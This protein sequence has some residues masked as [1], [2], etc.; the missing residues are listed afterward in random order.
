MA[1]AAKYGNPTEF[2]IELH[3]IYAAYLGYFESTDL[4]WW[5]KSWGGYFTGFNE[6]LQH[7]WEV[8]VVVNTATGRAHIAAR[9]EQ[10]ALFARMI[11]TR[12]G[13]SLPKDP[14][15]T[16]PLDPVPTKTLSLRR[17]V[18]V[19]D[20]ASYKKLSLT[21][22]AAELAFLRQ[23][24]RSGTVD[25][26]ERLFHEGDEH[27]AGYTWACVQTTWWDRGGAPSG[28]IPGSGR[29][30]SASKGLVLEVGMA[31]L[32]CANLRA[33]NVWPPVPEENYRKAH[34]IVEEWVDKR[35]NYNPPSYPRSYGFG[36]SHF[37]SEREMPRILDASIAAIASQGTENQANTLILIGCGD[38]SP[39]PLA[40]NSSV[41]NN[42][43]YLDVLALEYRFLRRARD[44]GVT[45]IPDRHGPLPHLTALLE[46]LQI[47]TTPNVP[48]GNAGNEA[49]YILLAF[50]KLMLADTSIPNVLYQVNTYQEV[51]HIRPFAHT[52]RRFS[53]PSQIEGPPPSIARP[54]S[55]ML[56]D[57]GGP[58]TSSRNTAPRARTVYWDDAHHSSAEG[59]PSPPRDRQAL[60]R[61]AHST[62][63]LPVGR[64]AS[65]GPS[66]LREPLPL[67]SDKDGKRESKMRSDKSVKD[68]AG[69]LARFW[70]G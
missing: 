36:R 43:L 49:F 17:L 55:G 9:S 27:G 57:F 51:P 63:T 2:D 11:R 21:L 53:S 45:G 50:Q 40:A 26:I 1:E 28:I 54:S 14:P 33:V 38:Q 30:A 19:S 5:E 46:V 58:S 37:V 23:R 52:Q 8:M 60:K 70:V 64:S 32:R 10:I 29:T 12:Y 69:A 7:G 15:T 41:P 59:S 67:S 6:F 24:V 56:E 25:T 44:Q 22:P 16:L 61:N 4:S 62:S 18:K 35:T 42:V 48:L 65:Q 47:P 20:L 39:L 13:E 34:F 31:V 66:P 3:S 68:L